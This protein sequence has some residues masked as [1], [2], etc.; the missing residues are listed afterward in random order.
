VLAL[1]LL[2]ALS[3]GPVRAQEGSSDPVHTDDLLEIGD[4]MDPAVPG[5]ADIQG[6]SVQMGPDWGDLFD[7]DRRMQDV[8]DELGNAGSNGVPDFLD[9]FGAL[10]LRRD[11]VFLLD[12]IS[13]G[14]SVDETIYLGP[15]SVG[16]GTVAPAYDLGNIYA[17][18]AFN[19]QKELVIYAGVE[20]LAPGA[21][22][23]DFE[24]N[25]SSFGIGEGGTI[26]GERTEGDLL[27]RAEF[28]GPLLS[29]LEVSQWAL[30]DPEAG[31]YGW[32]PTEVLPVI[33]EESAEQCNDAATLCVLCNGSPVAGGAWPSY[34]ETGGTTTEIATNS[35]M[36]IGV[37]VSALLGRHTYDNFY[38]TR[39]VSMQLSTYDGSE[40][41]VAQDYALGGFAR[42]SQLVNR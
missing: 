30:T 41:P 16:P 26:E 35:F 17:Y 13:A 2:L 22:R 14:T 1:V 29:A 19:D 31:T 36:E 27:I 40:T 18:S 32:S 33:P 10:R 38:A 7:A 8:Y 24:F 21:G 39:Y 25:Q 42:A 12:D 4:G 20:R 37:N 3:G 23:I 28:S 15:A 5:A 9:T 11:A 34:D 6:S